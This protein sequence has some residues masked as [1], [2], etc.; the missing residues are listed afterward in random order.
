MS[1]VGPHLFLCDISGSVSPEA[2]DRIL[3]PSI[4]A[5]LDGLAAGRDV[6]VFV[7][8]FDTNLR[9]LPFEITQQM[10]HDSLSWKSIANNLFGRG[11]TDVRQSLVEAVESGFVTENAIGRISVL[12]DLYASGFPE[13]D[14]L[15][16]RSV[17]VEFLAFPDTPV[18]DVEAFA[19]QVASWATVGSADFS[20]PTPP[21]L[22]AEGVAKPRS[23]MRP[24]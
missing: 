11:G 19:K 24:R 22:S 5:K 4:Q 21:T 18:K 6:P 15:A 1:T 9:G 14:C 10:A 8:G 16:G 7:C 23:A 12:S 13:P 17:S 3:Y 20:L 2:F